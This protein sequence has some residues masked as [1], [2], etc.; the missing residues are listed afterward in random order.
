VRWSH[1]GKEL[2]Y[3]ALDGKMMVV[4]ITVEAD[5]IVPG[6]PVA[7]FQT[8][9]WGGGGLNTTNRQ[10]YDVS[11]DG[12]FLIDTAIDETVAPITVILNWKPPAQ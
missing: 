10:Q 8:K 1:N 7:L 3:I 5:R 9:L 11:A 4:P 2:Y 12:R 6:T